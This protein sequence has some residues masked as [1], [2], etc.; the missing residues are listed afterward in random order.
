MRINEDFNNIIIQFNQPIAVALAFEE[1][2]NKKRDRALRP[3]PF[4]TTSG[5]S[6]RRLVQEQ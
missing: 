6:L 4:D 2:K 1:L 5:S 3:Y